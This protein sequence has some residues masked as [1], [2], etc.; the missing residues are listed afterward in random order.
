M[1]VLRFGDQGR[2]EVE[3]GKELGTDL[4]GR[5]RLALCKRWGGRT[6]ISRA[7]MIF[8]MVS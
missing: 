8:C 4:L 6:L 2:L 5:V 1:R 7:L 3:H